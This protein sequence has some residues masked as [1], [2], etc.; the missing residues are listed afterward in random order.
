M[1][2]KG[3]PTGNGEAFDELS[4]SLRPALAALLAVL[5]C[6]CGGG[7]DAGTLVE[8]WALGREGEHVRALVPAFEA[9]HPG[10]TVHVQQIPWSAAHE[11]LR[12]WATRCPT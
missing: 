8:F 7:P 3:N 11:K 6:G 2:K 12:L 4:E 1:S 5:L 9:R 10:V